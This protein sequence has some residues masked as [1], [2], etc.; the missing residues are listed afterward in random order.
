M[1]LLENQDA[2]VNIAYKTTP[3]I[4]ALARLQNDDRQKDDLLKSLLFMLEMALRDAQ[5]P[6][7]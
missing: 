5:E 1:L 7:Q 2:R 4:N 6:I 3:D